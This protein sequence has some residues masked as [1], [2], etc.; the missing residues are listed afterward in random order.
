MAL[1]RL[2]PRP[3]LQQH[4]VL[5]Q[6]ALEVRLG[7]EPV[8]Q[9]GG[10]AST[11]G[12]GGPAR[13][14]A[15]EHHSDRAVAVPGLEVRAVLV[16][17]GPVVHE[18]EVQALEVGTRMGGRERL[19]RG[20]LHQLA[21]P[22][23]VGGTRLLQGVVGLRDVAQ[24]VGRELLVVPPAGDQPADEQEDHEGPEGDQDYG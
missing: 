24:V 10:G 3:A 18:Y 11:A 17:P 2:A 8:D 5:G 23:P 6:P 14:A 22:A 21:I 4:R 16:H 1:A 13:V 12:V 20:A 19:A 15:G 7:L 9:V